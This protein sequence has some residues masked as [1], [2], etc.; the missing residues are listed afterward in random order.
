[1]KIEMMKQPKTD[2]ELKE[3]LW[4]FIQGIVKAVEDKTNKLPGTKE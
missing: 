4:D 2:E 3:I 1:M